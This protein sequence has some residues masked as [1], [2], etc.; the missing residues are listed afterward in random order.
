[1]HRPR[2]GKSSKTCGGQRRIE[3]ESRVS[4][5]YGHSCRNAPLGEQ[6]VLPKWLRTEAQR[7]I[8]THRHVAVV[9]R[10]PSLA[11]EG[12]LQIGGAA[13]EV[14]RRYKMGMRVVASNGVGVYHSSFLY[15]LSFEPDCRPHVEEAV[16]SGSSTTCAE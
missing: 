3:T 5:D 15:I 13:M 16:I 4:E 6:T 14:L 7:D 11:V 9:G 1:M 10:H 8:A 2:S 12:Q